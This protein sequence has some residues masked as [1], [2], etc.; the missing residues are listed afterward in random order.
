MCTH[1]ADPG[2]DFGLNLDMNFK[3]QNSLWA[4][5]RK[6]PSG[7]QVYEVKITT[8]TRVMVVQVFDILNQRK[9][10]MPLSSQ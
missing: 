5:L 3:F 8:M 1:G 6:A 7:R 10:A 9:R 2:T 4:L